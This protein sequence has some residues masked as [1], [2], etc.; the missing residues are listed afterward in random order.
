[1]TGMHHY[2]CQHDKLLFLKLPA[3]VLVK[4]TAHLPCGISGLFPP[5]SLEGLSNQPAHPSCIMWYVDTVKGSTQRPDGL[6]RSQERG[7]QR[8][9]VCGLGLPVLKSLIIHSLAV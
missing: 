2:P 4:T 5:G 1:M 8:V 9:T 7:Q 3:V 6:S